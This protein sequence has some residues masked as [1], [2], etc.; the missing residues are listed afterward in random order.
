MEACQRLAGRAEER[1]RYAA[2]GKLKITR[3]LTFLRIAIMRLRFLKKKSVSLPFHS[4]WLL[5]FSNY[6]HYNSSAVPR[7]GLGAV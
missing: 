7:P 2:E 1:A 4:F 6:L 5:H 3:D